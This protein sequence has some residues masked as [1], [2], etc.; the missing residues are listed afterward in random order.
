[1]PYKYKQLKGSKKNSQ[2]DPNYVPRV[3][4]VQTLCLSCLQP[5]TKC[6]AND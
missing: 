6:F 5:M 4:V 2:N 3:K 1:M